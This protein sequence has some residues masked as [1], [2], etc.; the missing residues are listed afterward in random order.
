MA[1]VRAGNTATLLADGR[2][3]IAGGFGANGDVLASAELFQP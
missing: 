2:V 3:L 1:S